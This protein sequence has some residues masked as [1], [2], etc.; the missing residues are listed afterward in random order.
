MSIIIN[1]K[2]CNKE[3]KT[4][5]CLEKRKKYCSKKCF[6]IGCPVSFSGKHHTQL[7]KDKLRLFHIGFKLSKETKI[8]MGLSRKGNNNPNWQGGKIKRKCIFCNKEFFVIFSL[9]K[10]GW[11]KFCSRKCK[12]LWQ[13]KNIIGENHPN[14]KGGASFEPY[15][16]GWTKTFKEQIR[17]RDKYKCQKCGIPEVEYGKRLD[18]HHR[19]FNK[20]NLDLNNLISLCKSCHMKI[21]RQPI[22][23][24][25][26]RHL[27]E[28]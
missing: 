18:V 20:N 16:L 17:Y 10:K 25:I 24:S 21:T 6:Y 27:S 1:C 19:D 26:N 7:V 2:I 22:W 12:E 8:K 15:P 23:Q 9:I 13:S 14:W 11:A 4:Y 5:K 3:I 28:V